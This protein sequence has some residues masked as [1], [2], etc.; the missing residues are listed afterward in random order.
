[1]SIHVTVIN[2]IYHVLYIM[3]LSQ[4]VTP[5]RFPPKKHPA[6][7]PP[8]SR[9]RPCDWNHWP[10]GLSVGV[11][12]PFSGQPFFAYTLEDERLE[13]T[14]H[15]FRKEND[16]KRTSMRTCSMWIFRGVI[17][18]HIELIAT[19]INMESI[20]F[21]YS[22]STEIEFLPVQQVFITSK[23]SIFPSQFSITEVRKLNVLLSGSHYGIN[24]A[25]W[26]KRNMAISNFQSCTLSEGWSNP[27][28]CP[29]F[30]DHLIMGSSWHRKILYIYIFLYL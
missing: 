29:L 12:F 10:G 13:P 22:T 21:F 14:N 3:F 20:D 26:N 7:K 24:K 15:P 11:D 5:G 2:S 1:M 30:R 18:L 25:S 4:L 16:L 6:R 8:S 23:L 17:I 27:I 19:V 28:P 9:V